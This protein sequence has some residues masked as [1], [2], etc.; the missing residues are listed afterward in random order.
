MSNQNRTVTPKSAKNA[1]RVALK[2]KRP[3]M[4]WGAAGIGKSDIFHQIGKETERNVRDVRLALW[5]PTDIKGIPYRGDDN[6]MHWSVPVELPTNPESTD[7]LFLDELP[8][9]PPATQAA[10]YQLILN[11]R[12]GNYVLPTGVDIVA[13]GNRKTDKGVTYEMPAPLSNRF[14]HLELEPSFED[15]QEWAISNNINSQVIGY[16]T[17]RKD[18]LHR[19]DPKSASRSFPT[20]RSWSFVSQ[21]LE[22]S[23]CDEKTLMDIVSGCIGEGTAVQFMAHRKVCHKLPNPTDILEGKVTTLQ[24]NEMSALSSLNVSLCYEINNLL[25]NLGKTKKWYGYV[26]RYLEFIMSGVFEPELVVVGFKILISTYG[27]M[28]DSSKLTQYAK[29]KKEYGSYILSA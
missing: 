19:F 15:F 16:L 1:I 20:P 6:Q 5:D 26:D 11:R 7:I 14:I 13:A 27:I 12:V 21:I 23:D 25:K 24:T 10:A 3:L 28:L 2:H 17:F 18:D 9:A 8:S 4:V 22:D 29:F